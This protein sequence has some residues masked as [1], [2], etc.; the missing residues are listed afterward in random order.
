MSGASSNPNCDMLQYDIK[1]KEEEEEMQEAELRL[2]AD[3]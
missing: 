2:Q 1:S 3:V